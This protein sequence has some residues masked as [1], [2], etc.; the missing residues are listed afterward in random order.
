MHTDIVTYY[1]EHRVEIGYCRPIGDVMV[2]NI[3]FYD[4]CS[5]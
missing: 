1:S 2:G 3:T 4:F 5:F